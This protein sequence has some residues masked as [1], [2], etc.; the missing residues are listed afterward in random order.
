[1]KLKGHS[2]LALLAVLLGGC[3]LSHENTVRIN[4]PPSTQVRIQ[5]QNN[6]FGPYLLDTNHFKPAPSHGSP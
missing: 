1:M 2:M 3:E 4:R 5:N 6:Y